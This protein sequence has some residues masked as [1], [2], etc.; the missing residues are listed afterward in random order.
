M[1]MEKGFTPCKT[2]TFSVVLTGER[3]GAVKLVSTF[4]NLPMVKV[5]R[6]GKPGFYMGWAHKHPN[7]CTVTGRKNCKDRQCELHYMDAPLKL[8]PNGGK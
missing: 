4:P 1:E 7:I 3:H 6:V 2:R 5:R 8:A